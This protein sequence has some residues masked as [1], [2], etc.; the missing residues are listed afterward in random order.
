MEPAREAQNIYTLENG[1]YTL[2]SGSRYS[3][4][5]NQLG[6]NGFDG[7]VNQGSRAEVPEASLNNRQNSEA[8]SELAL[9]A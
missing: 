9:A 2:R 7:A 4:H 3:V 1:C 8:N 6:A 5:D